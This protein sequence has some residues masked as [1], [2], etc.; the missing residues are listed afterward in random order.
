MQTSF[1]KLKDISLNYYVMCL[2]TFKVFDKTYKALIKSCRKKLISCNNMLKDPKLRELIRKHMEI[3]DIGKIQDYVIENIDSIRSKYGN[4]YDDVI[5]KDE[6]SGKFLLYNKEVAKYFSIFSDAD[7]NLMH[8]KVLINMT[9]IYLLTIFEAF[10]NDYFSELI[11]NKPI[12][13]TSKK[14]LTFKEILEN[15]SIDELHYTMAHILVNNAIKENNI[16]EFNRKF[17]IKNFKINLEEY[18]KYKNLRENYYRRN[19]IVHNKGYADEKYIEM[20]EGKNSLLGKKIPITFIYVKRCFFDVY[21][22]IKFI[23]LQ[24]KKKFNVPTHWK[25][26]IS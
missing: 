5:Y 1:E 11:S 24:M 19:I 20:I 16:D 6:K 21:E 12:I 3:M 2:Q 25:F 18:K 15:K 14:T 4:Y 9:V 13:M 8:C 17:L 23:E 7:L 10:N 22:Y 26:N